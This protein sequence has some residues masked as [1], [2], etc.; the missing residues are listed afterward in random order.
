MT[1][2]KSTG[3]HSAPPVCARAVGLDR[4]MCLPA[5]DGLRQRRGVEGP[6]KEA[7]GVEARFDRF[8]PRGPSALLVEPDRSRDHYRLRCRTPIL[9]KM[10]EAMPKP[11]SAP[12]ITATDVLESSIRPITTGPRAVPATMSIVAKL[13]I[14]PNRSTP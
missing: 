13:R 5:Q 9:A 3:C 2:A 1:C 11:M 10:A 7:S 8:R 12:Q 4:I 6:T 14:V